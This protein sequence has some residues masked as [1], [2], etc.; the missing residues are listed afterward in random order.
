M[1]AACGYP[2][3]VPAQ[4]VE[5]RTHRD[6]CQFALE[7]LDETD[8]IVLRHLAGGLIVKAKADA[9]LVT[10]ADTEVET[11]IRERV[12]DA[13]P[14]HGVLGEEFGSEAGASGTRWI[15]DPIDGTHNLVRGIPVFGTL[16]AVED[17]GELVVAAIS[18][19]AMARRWWAVRGDGAVAR[20]HLGERPIHVSTVDRLEEAQLVTSG[21]G[22]LEQAGFGSAA[23]RLSTRVWRD[24]GFGE[25]WG[26]MLVAEGAADVMLEIGPT[27]WDLAAPSLI[28]REAGG[29]LTDFAGTPSHTGPQALATNGRLHA[30]IVAALAG[31]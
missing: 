23:T 2:S 29:R 7:L 5:R 8:A 13:F 11:R 26:Y 10:Q 31:E 17:G 4:H 1:A 24:R 25:F 16:L 22:P 20:D 6:L 9:T 19:P 18:A 3:R 30:A 15:V 12:A 14:D 21:L 28:V 27:L